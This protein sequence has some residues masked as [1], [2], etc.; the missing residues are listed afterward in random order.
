MRPRP[1]LEV[2]PPLLRQPDPAVLDPFHEDRV[3]QD[4]A[5]LAEAPGLFEQYVERARVRF[6]KAGE[7]AILERW[8]KFYQA[9]ERLVVAKT[10]MERGKI[11]YRQLAYEHEV[12]ETEK[13]ESLA[14]L[15]ADIEEHNLRR[16]KAA[17]QREHLDRFVDPSQNATVSENEQKL[18]DA[19]ERREL[20]TR[21]ELRESLSALNTLI[22]LQHWRRQERDRILQDRS[23]T[24][25]EQGEDLQFVEELYEKKRTELKV[26]TRIFEEE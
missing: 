21:W 7:R 19:S 14:K 22:E 4:L 10:A 26:D 15:Q 25:Q 1:K 20:D 5:R 12:R 16:D 6:Q 18:R 23:L 13:R 9:G 24:S 17:H 2:L 3:R 11:D 8:I